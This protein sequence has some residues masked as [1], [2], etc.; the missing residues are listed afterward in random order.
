IYYNI[1]NHTQQEK[2]LKF[3]KKPYSTKGL[4]KVWTKTSDKVGIIAQLQAL[5]DKNQPRTRTAAYRK[6]M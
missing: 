5:G 2:T 1:Y 4:S 6:R 3:I